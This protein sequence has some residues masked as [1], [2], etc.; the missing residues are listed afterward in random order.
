MIP[1]SEATIEYA[2]RLGKLA[3]E[4]PVT[5]VSAAQTETNR[6]LAIESAKQ[7][8][9]KIPEV[10]FILLSAY[11]V[12]GVWEVEIYGVFDENEAMLVDAE[13]II[14]YISYEILSHFEVIKPFEIHSGEM[15][16]LRKFIS[17]NS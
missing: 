3:R 2:K 13:K 9:E 1:Y 14:K 8:I 10:H 4:R 5:L 6:L 11:E 16:D 17:E 12:W 15:L 7:I